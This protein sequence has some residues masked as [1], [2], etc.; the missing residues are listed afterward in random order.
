[1]FAAINDSLYDGYKLHA[2]LPMNIYRKD[3]YHEEKLEL[4]LIGYLDDTT[5]F[6][7]KIDDLVANLAIADD[8]YSLANIKINKEKTKLLTND[9][10]LLA[11]DDKHIPFYFGN[12]LINIEIVPKNSNERILGIYVNINNSPT[13]TY[14]KIKKMLHYICYNLRKKKITHDHVIYIINKVL[15]PRIEYLTQHILV[16]PHIINEFN[17]IIR[18]IYKHSLSLPKSFFNSVIH[19]P[20]YPNILNIWDSQLRAQASLLNAQINNP[21]TSPLIQFLILTS[22]NRLWTND[23]GETTKYFHKPMK[24]F[25]RLENLLCIFHY[26]NLS[27]FHSIKYHVTGG[28]HPISYFISDPKQYFKFLRSLKHKD[29]FFLDQIISNDGAFL[30]TWKEIKKTLR[31]KS[32]RRPKWY[33]FLKENIVLNNN[34]NRLQFTT[35]N[36]NPS[37]SQNFT[38]PKI[39]KS[40]NRSLPCKNQWTSFWSPRYSDIIYIKIIEKSHF[41]SDVPKVYGEH[42]IPFRDPIPQDPSLTPHSMPNLLIP[43]PGCDLHDS[44]YIGDIRPRCIIS[45]P[46]NNTISVHANIYR[47]NNNRQN[48]IFIVHKSHS[49]TRADVFIDYNE[50]I[51]PNFRQTENII[52]HSPLFN[53]ISQKNFQLI[54]TI[55]LP[56]SIHNFFFSF[57]NLISSFN[58]LEFYTDGSLLR[59]NDSSIMGFGWILTNDINLD[60]KF[61]GKTVEW[62]SST[63]AEIFAILTCLII[64]PPNSHVTI[65]TDSQCAIDTYYSLQHYKMTPRRLQKLNNVLLWQAIKWIIQS[66]N[67]T[68]KLNK[69]QA[70]SGNTYNDIADTLAKA[71]CEQPDIISI[72]PVGVKPQKGYIKFNE[73]FIIDRN[74]RKTLKKPINF[75]NIE[76]QISHRSLHIIKTF[77]LEHRINWEYTQYWMSFNP[78]HKA[79]SQTYSKHVSWRMK[80][81]NYALPTLDALNR[82]YPD[83]LKGFDTCFLCSNSTETNEHFWTCSESINIL[84]NIFRKYESIYNSLIINNINYDKFKN[85]IPTITESPVFTC[86]NS[87]ISTIFDAPDLHCIL[88]NMI[89]FSIIKPF[90]DAKISKKEI[91]KLLLTFLFDLHK[92]IYEL[93]WKVQTSKWKQYKLDLG[94][95]KS[96]FTKRINT[97]RER[98]RQNNFD[99]SH[100]NPLNDN[101]LNIG[102]SN[103]FM[104]STR[105]LDDSVL[106]IY[107]TS[108]NF[109]HNLPWI[110]SLY[111]TIIDSIQFDTNLFY[112]NI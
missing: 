31:S 24:L 9:K 7:N 35:N 104:T 8:F 78:F 64:C 34:T 1:M 11:K 71:G 110:N 10:T 85:E 83:I 51:N 62:A 18:S 101:I 82:N 13:F 30:K 63:R 81:S 47:K 87:N 58:S 6:A 67:L 70:H 14:K 59:Y 84:K 52:Q 100:N 49:E 27:F 76:R 16:P 89:P 37:P 57:A 48:N 45:F 97:R 55:L 68:I 17:R 32:G 72:S 86:F 56:F 91:K 36:N 103:P 42:H 93:L 66:L 74:I 75:R 73:E 54:K 33:D 26:Y 95:T 77:T 109:R 80:C 28:V 38:R 99:I 20:I 4:K 79:T 50:R 21:I 108:S 53:N 90:Q 2:T 5:W 40:N 102:Y 12:D 25:N 15:L 65:F 107:L 69:V 106:W 61:S 41:P 29:I 44:F 19:N 43:C 39:I 46:S 23:I 60:L 88:I 94:I 98:K 92:D 96:T 105:N 22:Q 111:L 112:Y 3:D